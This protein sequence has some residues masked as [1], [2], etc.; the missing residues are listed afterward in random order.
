MMAPVGFEASPS[1]TN[2]WITPEPVGCCA[3]VEK[4]APEV[5]TVGPLLLPAVVKLIIAA[6]AVEA[7]KMLAATVAAASASERTIVPCF[8]I[9]SF[10][11]IQAVSLAHAPQ[12]LTVAQIQLGNFTALAVIDSLATPDWMAFSHPIALNR[13]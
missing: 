1:R 8:I 10:F 2:E 5:V 13:Q 6:F 11:K 4:I 7:A 12:Q 9:P 3:V